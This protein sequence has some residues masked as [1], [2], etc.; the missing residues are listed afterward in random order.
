[1]RQFPVV[2]KS[3]GF[4]GRAFGVAEFEPFDQETVLTFEA[5]TKSLAFDNKFSYSAAYFYNDYSDLQL[6]GFGQDP[7]TNQFVSLFTNAA[8]AK[9]QGV[10][11]VVSYRATQQLS[12]NASAG[13]LDAEYDEFD[14]LVNGV[15]TD[16]S[17]RR[18]PNAPEWTGFLGA[19]YTDFIGDNLIG[20]L[21][22][23]VAYKGDH[24]N[25]STDSPNLAVDSAVYL[26]AFVSVASADDRWEIRN[27]RHEPY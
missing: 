2:F 13:Y 11:A 6:N 5:G 3:G 26:N 10:E 4:P 17:D 9:I 25:E 8:S 21:H 16:V 14:T 20:T 7:V 12:I 23:D 22:F 1:M 27:R 19:T 18:L 15:L 24:A